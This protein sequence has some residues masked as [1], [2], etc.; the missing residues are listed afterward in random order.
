MEREQTSSFF[1]PTAPEDHLNVS[2]FYDALSG[3]LFMMAGYYTAIARTTPRAAA[4]TF[5]VVLVNTVPLRISR[6]AYVASCEK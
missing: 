6:E 5:G 3:A 1:N 2:R 4:F